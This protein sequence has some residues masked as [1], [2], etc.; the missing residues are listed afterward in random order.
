MAAPPPLHVTY[1]ALG[2]GGDGGAVFEAARSAFSLCRLA[3]KASV[4]LVTN[5]EAPP[6][7]SRAGVSAWSAKGSG[8]SC[9]GAL[10]NWTVFRKTERARLQFNGGSWVRREAAAGW[11][12]DFVKRSKGKGT[13][14][15]RSRR[16]QVG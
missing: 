13:G 1:L 9:N 7:F 16:R 10:A 14:L 2:G 4:L 8:R 12:W 15:T 5:M 3:P 11:A 6:K